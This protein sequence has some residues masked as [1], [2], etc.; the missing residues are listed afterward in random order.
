MELINF[1]AISGLIAA[2]PFSKIFFGILLVLSFWVRRCCHHWTLAISEVPFRGPG[3]DFQRLFTAYYLAP[4]S[5]KR[6]EKGLTHKQLG[7]VYGLT[8]STREQ[9]GKDDLNV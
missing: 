8:L 6:D 4:E 7:V 2:P 5:G 1:L 9:H 3:K